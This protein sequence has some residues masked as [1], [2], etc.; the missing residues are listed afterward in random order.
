MAERILVECG[1]PGLELKKIVE[2]R[3]QAKLPHVSLQFLVQ[4]ALTRSIGSIVKEFSPPS[5]TKN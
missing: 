1:P 3:K 5:K 2:E 4:T